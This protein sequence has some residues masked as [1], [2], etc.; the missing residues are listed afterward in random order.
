MQIGFPPKNSFWRAA[1]K[2]AFGVGKSTDVS[3]WRWPLS[4]L[5]MHSPDAEVAAKA[6]FNIAPAAG[7]SAPEAADLSPAPAAQLDNQALWWRRGFDAA[8]NEQDE[9]VRKA[10]AVVI[11]GAEKRVAAAELARDNAREEAAEARA[12]ADKL[13]RML[14][15]VCHRYVRESDHRRKFAEKKATRERARANRAEVACEA[16]EKA[17]SDWWPEMCDDHE[18]NEAMFKEHQRM[19]DARSHA[20]ATARQPLPP[21]QQ[22]EGVPW[23]FLYTCDEEDMLK[24]LQR[25]VERADARN[26]EEIKCESEQALSNALTILGPL[27]SRECTTEQVLPEV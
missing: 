22:E 19:L 20:M 12:E 8:C 1:A 3:A 15:H 21:Q 25:E 7:D 27:E 9:H 26:A 5:F 17:F 10:T 13:N 23:E 14:W 24:L 18:I 4:R 11:S 6:G 16:Y 2:R